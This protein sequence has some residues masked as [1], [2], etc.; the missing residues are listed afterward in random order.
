MDI[1]RTYDR[2]TFEAARAAWYDADLRGWDTIR[3]AGAERGMLYPPTGSKWDSWD[4][5]D[6][7]QV[8]VI[9]QL[10]QEN[11]DELLR[12]VRASRSW[13][14]VVERVIALR[15]HN[16]ELV[17]IRLDDD[18]WEAAQERRRRYGDPQS[19]GAI[20]RRLGDSVG[21]QR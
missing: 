2:A 10:R 14:Q 11:P 15:D 5:R 20:L 21:V 8:A 13:S 3:A 16:R 9:E 6:P 18:E 12:I 17:R 19:L 1:V 7:S 4:D